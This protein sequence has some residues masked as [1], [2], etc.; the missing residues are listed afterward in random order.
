MNQLQQLC[1]AYPGVSLEV[2]PYTV[3]G[4]PEL[5]VTVHSCRYFA[6]EVEAFFKDLFKDAG[7]PV[8]TGLWPNIQS[9]FH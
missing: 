7:L 1:K 3:K 2:N 4:D 9:G 5:G 8:E 6:R